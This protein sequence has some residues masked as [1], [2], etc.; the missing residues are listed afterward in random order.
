MRRLFL[1][2]VLPLLPLPAQQVPGS[3]DAFA[4]LAYRS[5][6][7]FRGG[8]VTAVT[9]VSR[10]PLTFYQ[11]ATGGGVWKTTDAGNTWANVSDKDFRTGSFGALGVAPSNPAIVWAG[12]G[13]APIRTNASHGDGVYRSLDG[14]LTWMNMGLK[15]TRHISRISLNDL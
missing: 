10:Q 6:G 9:G 12:M 5:I 13:E 4:D 3:A 15:A 1:A 11:G 2:L 8:R 14:G 7:P